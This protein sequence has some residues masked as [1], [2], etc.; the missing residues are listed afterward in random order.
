MKVATYLLY[1]DKATTTFSENR[2]CLEKHDSL[3]KEMLVSC[4]F[5]QCKSKCKTIY[6]KIYHAVHNIPIESSHIRYFKVK[7]SATKN[8][9]IVFLV[10]SLVIYGLVHHLL[11]TVAYQWPLCQKKYALFIRY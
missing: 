1:L 4:K 10:T 6:C 9:T 8:I 3:R 7:T 2:T 5:H 11:A